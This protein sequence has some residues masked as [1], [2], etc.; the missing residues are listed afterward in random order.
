[1][2]WSI[3]CKREVV[4]EVE[5]QLQHSIFGWVTWSASQCPGALSWI[6]ITL[7]VKFNLVRHHSTSHMRQI[8]RQSTANAFVTHVFL[9]ARQNTGRYTWIHKNTCFP[10]SRHMGSSSSAYS[11]PQH[12]NT[13]IDWRDLSLPWI[14]VQYIQSW[15]CTSCLACVAKF[16]SNPVLSAFNTCSGRYPLSSIIFF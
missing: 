6:S 9:L 16:Q 15:R 2:P 10:F 5:I 14:L 11:Q 1:M 4:F 13:E 8:F 3:S 7:R 12:W